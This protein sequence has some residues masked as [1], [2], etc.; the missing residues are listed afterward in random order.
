MAEQESVRLAELADDGFVSLPEDARSMLRATMYG[1][2]LTAGF[3]PRIVQ[4]APDSATVLALVAAGAGV[5]I[6]L[7]SVRPAQSVGIVYKPIEGTG[8]AHLYAA[9]AW[10]SDNTSP[11]LAR[12]LEVSEWALPTPIHTR[13]ISTFP[14]S[15]LD[16]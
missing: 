15:V 1:M 16:S 3:P 7:S 13:K 11:A 8:P 12:V 4:V 2:C 10:R 9:I 5:T 6:T 14:D